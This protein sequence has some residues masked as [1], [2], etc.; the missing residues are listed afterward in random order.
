MTINY[1]LNENLVITETGRIQLKDLEKNLIFYSSFDVNTEADY[2]VGDSV[3]LKKNSSSLISAEGPI[4]FGKALAGDTNT[5]LYKK[6]NF[7]DVTTTGN[8]SMWCNFY[9]LG[10]TILIFEVVDTNLI[11]DTVNN[12]YRIGFSYNN[13]KFNLRMHGDTGAL[14]I[15][16]EIDD[17]FTGGDTYH[18]LELNW[19]KN[20]HQLYIDGEQVNDSVEGITRSSHGS[21]IININPDIKIDDLVIRN[22]YKHIENFDIPTNVFS[23]YKVGNIEQDIPLGDSFEVNKILGAEIAGDTTLKFI[24]KSGDDYFNTVNNVWQEISN[25]EYNNSNS[26]Y[27]IKN[28]ITKFD[29]VKTKSVIIKTFFPSEGLKQIYLDNLV[30]NKDLS[31]VLNTTNYSD[32]Y[33][34]IRAKLGDPT[35]PVELTN[36]QLSDCLDDAIYYYGRYKN[37]KEEMEIFNLNGAWATGWTLPDSV[38]EEDIIE[39]FLEPTFPFGYYSGKTDIV[40]NLYAQYIFSNPGTSNLSTGVADYR[41]ALSALEDYAILLGTQVKW[42]IIG[43][44]LKIWPEPPVGTQIGIKYASAVVAEDV[45]K[46]NLFKELA[47]AKAKIVLGTIRSTFAGG[48]PGGT[49]NIQLNG[50]SLIQE[51]KNEEQITIEKLVKAQEPLF[52]DFF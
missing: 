15:N 49:E 50:E 40:S 47:L 31:E 20:L 42:L 48:I 28:N 16:D 29:F 44:K 38:K 18:H 2:S 7:V 23:K 51:G 11:G 34:Y 36:E 43:R 10:D 35:I 21:L 19:N 33:R 27:E 13:S 24:L 6:E 37:T 5:I 17:L 1:T 25:P 14:V 41:I 46:D 9:Q 39:I 32:V 3:P 26:I 4:P 30:I 45:L 52:L 22:K 8:I 12:N